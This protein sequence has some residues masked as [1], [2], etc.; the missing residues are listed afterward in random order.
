MDIKRIKLNKKVVLVR[1]NGA[2]VP[3]VVHSDVKL[4]A[5]GQWVEV[6]MGTKKEPNIVRCRPSKLEAA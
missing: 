5:N 1:R 4:E 3:A 2:K 6:N